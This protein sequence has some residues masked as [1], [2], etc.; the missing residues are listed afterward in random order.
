MNDTE[1]AFAD[2]VVKVLKAAGYRVFFDARE[3]PGAFAVKLMAERRGADPSRGI[4]CVVSH[5]EYWSYTLI[6]FPGTADRRASG[7]FDSPAE[8]AALLNAAWKGEK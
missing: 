1:K 5:V 2:E 4:A 8:L 3:N 6:W 7:R